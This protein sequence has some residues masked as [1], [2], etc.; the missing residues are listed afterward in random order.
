MGQRNGYRW[1]D[2]LQGTSKKSLTKSLGGE[3]IEKYRIENKSITTMTMVQRSRAEEA[4]RHKRQV[5]G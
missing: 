5:G 1:W 2:G 4:G 3:L